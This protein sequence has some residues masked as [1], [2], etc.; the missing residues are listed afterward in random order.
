MLNILG[1]CSLF[2][3]G[4]CN[5]QLND[6]IPHGNFIIQKSVQLEKSSGNAAGRKFDTRSY[7]VKYQILYKGKKVKLPGSLQKGTAYNYPWRVYILE[8]APRPSLIAASQNVFLITENEGTLKIEQ[9]NHN[10]SRFASIQWLDN[11]SGQPGDEIQIHEPQGDHLLDNPII[12]NEGRYLLINHFT[13]LDVRSLTISR[14]NKSNTHEYQGWRILLDRATG[15]NIAV[16]FSERFKQVVFPALKIDE[17]AEGKYNSALAAFEIT[18]DSITIVPFSRTRLRLESL[19][20]IDSLWVNN[21]FEWDSTGKLN[22]RPQITAP[23]WQGKLNFEDKNFINYELYPVNVSMVSAFQNFLKRK[24]SS[25]NTPAN[26]F[27]ISDETK[28]HSIQLLYKI[29]IDNKFFQLA[30]DVKDRKLRF[31]SHFS[32]SHTEEHRHIIVSIAN[33]FN[34]ELR[35]YL[36]DTHFEKYKEE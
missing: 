26:Q 35:Q 28:D 14:F 3:T 13:V 32:E 2:G 16:G 31:D 29:K 7:L 1:I 21:F 19:E 4:S 6:G 25:P 10:T 18:A 15:Y 5:A 9:V 20:S 36:H 11:K 17:K 12:L 23:P 22:L 8:G 34:K 27:E 30:Y 33:D 24:Y